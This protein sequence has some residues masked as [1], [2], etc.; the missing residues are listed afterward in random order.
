MSYSSPPKHLPGFFR[1][2]NLENMLQALRQPSSIATI[3]SLGAHGLF[4]V[5]LPLLTAQPKPVDPQRTVKL[6]ELTPAEQSRLPQVT[7][8]LTSPPSLT[9]TLP[10]TSTQTQPSKPSTADNTTPL[11]P[12]DESLYKFPPL[13][14]PPPV[15]IFPPVFQP[16]PL[17]RLPVNPRPPLAPTLPSQ[18]LPRA[19]DPPASPEPTTPSSP[20]NSGPAN[21]GPTGSPTPQASTAPTRP[22]RIPPA[23]IARLRELQQAGNDLYATS[24][25]TEEQGTSNL[26]SWLAQVK[27]KN[28]GLYEE[29]LKSTKVRDVT[30]KYPEAACAKE[31]SR[32]GAV[33]V[34]MGPD[35]KAIGE[36]ELLRKTGSKSLDKAALEAAKGFEPDPKAAGKPQ[37][38]LLRVTFEYKAENCPAPSA[39]PT[40]GATETPP[41]S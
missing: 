24:S 21:S 28:Q 30:A 41:A 39:T 6:I 2:Q 20:D 5:F 38:Y 31:L 36:P 27:E 3:V 13:I 7:S 25:D 32:L 9:A 22:D 23:A 33:G 4:F 11:P 34:L 37:L 40:P 16:P 1:Q 26:D 35:G 19:T 29:L 15:N 10:P 14:S 17:S 12:I 8:P 18:P